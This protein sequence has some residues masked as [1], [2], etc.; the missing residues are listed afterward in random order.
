MEPQRFSGI[1][2]FCINARITLNMKS[3]ILVIQPV[4][5]PATI[6]AITQRPFSI[7]FAFR[8]V[9]CPEVKQRLSL[10]GRT[11]RLYW[12]ENCSNC[13]ICFETFVK[14]LLQTFYKAVFLSGIGIA[15]NLFCHEIIQAAGHLAPKV[16]V[17]K[18]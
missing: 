13:T 2:Q 18:P 11:L 6:L 9:Q 10:P 17:G 1:I 7:N 15:N 14:A 8:V 3:Y 12:P 16:I 4:C 5:V